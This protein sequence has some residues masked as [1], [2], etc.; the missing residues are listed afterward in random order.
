M[1]FS[2][3]KK[4]HSTQNDENFLHE[5]YLP[6][7]F[8]IW[9]TREIDKYCYTKISNKIFADENNANYGTSAYNCN[10]ASSAFECLYARRKT[11]EPTYGCK[12]NINN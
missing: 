11:R 4:F 12:A 10:Q 9:H 1:K 8:N 5:Y 7:V 6:I 3:L 2:L